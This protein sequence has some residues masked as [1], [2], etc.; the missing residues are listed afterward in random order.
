[1]MP[2]G[3]EENSP[4]YRSTSSARFVLYLTCRLSIHAIDQVLVYVMDPFIQSC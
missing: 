4:S 1:M 3:F 2:A